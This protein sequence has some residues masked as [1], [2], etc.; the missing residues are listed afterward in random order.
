MRVCVCVCVCV[1]VIECFRLEHSEIKPIY[2][3]D[4]KTL[5][6]NYRPISLLPVFSK[7]FEKL[8]I[9]DYITL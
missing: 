5:I 6:T 1:C 2:K 8:C 9:K 7:M 4:N 3:K